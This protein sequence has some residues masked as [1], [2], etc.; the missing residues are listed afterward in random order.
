M[1]T[2]A[3]AAWCI[4]EC[5]YAFILL[6]QA[7]A[8]YVGSGAWL[9]E[10]TVQ[11]KFPRVLLRFVSSF[12]ESLVTL[13]DNTRWFFQ[14]AGLHDSLIHSRHTVFHSLLGS[15][16]FYLLSFFHRYLL[17]FYLSSLSIFS[18]Y[19][20][21]GSS[22]EKAASVGCAKA[23]LPRATSANICPL[24]LRNRWKSMQ[25]GNHSPWVQWCTMFYYVLLYCLISPLRLEPTPLSLLLQQVKNVSWWGGRLDRCRT[26]TSEAKQKAIVEQPRMSP[27]LWVSAFVFSHKGPSFIKLRLPGEHIWQL[28]AKCFHLM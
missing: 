14:P 16:S 18:I 12:F 5:F 24:A 10:V 26:E 6:L 21:L 20:L 2:N 23:L 27:P 13:S 7:S 8:R 4:L 17:S 1:N 9:K 19:L 22:A 25:D 11:R 15:S 28:F 3:G